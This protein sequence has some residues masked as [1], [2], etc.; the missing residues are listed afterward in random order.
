MASAKQIAWRKKFAKMAKS[1]KFKKKKAKKTGLPK[2][3]SKYT[4][5]LPPALRQRLAEEDKLKVECV[6]C[7][8]RMDKVDMPEHFMTHE[9]EIASKFS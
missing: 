8:K 2:G 9:S 5:N 1:G 3:Y 4:S 6:V 7:G